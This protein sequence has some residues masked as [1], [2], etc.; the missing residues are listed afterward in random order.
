MPTRAEI[1]QI[2]PPPP[3]LL[4]LAPP[5]TLSIFLPA[6]E[7]SP[8]DG[9]LAIERPHATTSAERLANIRAGMAAV[10]A[11]GPQAILSA[12]HGSNGA[13]PAERT[14]SDSEG[15]TSNH[16]DPEIM[17]A[18]GSATKQPKRVRERVAGAAGPNGGMATPR[19]RGRPPKDPALKALTSPAA[20]R[21]AKETA[22]ASPN[23]KAANAKPLPAFAPDAYTR[24][25]ADD[26]SP[27]TALTESVTGYSDAGDA[28][29]ETWAASVDE[30]R[31]ATAD[32]SGALDDRSSS[33]GAARR[34]G[35][36]L[37]TVPESWPCLS[38]DLPQRMTNGELSS[39][40]GGA[41][42]AEVH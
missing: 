22:A 13:H 1:T 21:A 9:K 6:G 20:K 28:A 16:L 5:P 38:V 15:S 25:P 31:G 42:S 35:A 30:Q 36:P 17:S 11:L 14:Q 40:E 12:T 41:L 24:A 7:V 4:P 19:K 29:E 39:V 18:P 32:G 33:V 10:S 26:R 3:P 2:S 34:G 23:A 27:V 8:R 37:L